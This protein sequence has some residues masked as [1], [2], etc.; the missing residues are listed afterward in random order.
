MEHEFVAALPRACR[1]CARAVTDAQSV[2]C[3]PALDV[4]FRR[5]QGLGSIARRATPLDATC[6]IVYCTDCIV[7]RLMQSQSCVHFL[8]GSSQENRPAC[9]SCGLH[10]TTRPL[11]AQQQNRMVDVR[12][13]VMPC[14]RLVARTDALP[15]YLRHD[16]CHVC[17]AC[18]RRLHREG[19]FRVQTSDASASDTPG[20]LRVHAINAADYVCARCAQPGA[21]DMSV[22]DAG[23]QDAYSDEPFAYHWRG[24]H[25]PEAYRRARHLCR[26]CVRA[27]CT[28][29]ELIAPA[30]SECSVL[31]DECA[32]TQ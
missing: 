7:R 2:Y 17:H 13:G 32:R 3:L 9:A 15:D 10:D 5:N 11:L 24:G 1:Q 30:P 27:L 23:V 20:A 4:W 6:A 31:L 29:G 14:V 18:L 16:A 12:G 22:S 19:I 25:A 8:L 26:E 28:E 21:R